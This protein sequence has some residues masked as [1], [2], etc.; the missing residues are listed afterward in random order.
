MAT[1]ELPLSFAQCPQCG[2]K[3]EDIRILGAAQIAVLLGVK[4]TTVRGWMS[5]GLLPFRLWLRNS[6]SVL[7]VVL[8]RDLRAF[9]DQ[10]FQ[11]PYLDP[12]SRA[13]RLWGWAQKNGSK[14][15]KKSAE[16]RKKARAEGANGGDGP[17][18][19]DAA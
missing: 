18:P 12:H 9:I 11:A 4:E 2:C 6:R 15:G 14:G 16:L 3:F 5:T 17:E 13:S 1:K 19:K 8:V 10:R 7:R